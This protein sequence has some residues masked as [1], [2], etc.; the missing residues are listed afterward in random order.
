MNSNVAKYALLAIKVLVALA[1]LA[2]GLAKLSGVQ[3]MVGTFDQIGLGQWFRYATGLIEVGGAILLFL[4]GRQAIGAALLVATMIGA[5]LSHILILGP[6][7]VPALTLGVL[8]AVI[9]INHRD[10]LTGT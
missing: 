2:A 10:Q 6:S 8:A 9:L 7:M 1:F 3:M 4:P 5:V